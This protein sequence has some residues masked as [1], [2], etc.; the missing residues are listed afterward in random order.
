MS[1]VYKSYQKPLDHNDLWH[2]LDDNMVYVF[3]KNKNEWKPISDQDGS[4]NPILGNLSELDTENKDSIIGAINEIARKAN[5]TSLETID[6]NNPLKHILREQGYGTIIHHWGVVGDSLASGEFVGTPNGNI[7]CYEYSWAH[8]FAK[9]NN[10]D[11]Y[12]FSHGGC[13]TAT[14][15]IGGSDHRNSDYAGGQQGGGWK[16]AKEEGMKRQAY[17]IA[18][19]VNDYLEMQ[20]GTSVYGI[21]TTADYR[22]YDPSRDT[23]YGPSS[24]C[25]FYMQI[26]NRLK[27]ANPGAKIFLMTTPKYGNW[28]YEE[29]N[30]AIRSIYQYYIDNNIFS[31]DVYLIDMGRYLETNLSEGP[32][33][34][35]THGS[36]FGYQYFAWCVNTYVDWIIRNNANNFKKIGFE[37][38]YPSYYDKNKI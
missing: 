13:S 5:E 23:S 32:Y 29:I 8:R 12:C 37:A 36:A 27:Y 15:L 20:A 16:V 25:S 22:A 4:S 24:F 34:L 1:Q 18:L 14:W 35:S 21:G 19:G 30:E 10:A 11:M 31:G 26:I 33:D 9:L 7:D 6:L 3:D 2:N 38:G 17:I 28:A